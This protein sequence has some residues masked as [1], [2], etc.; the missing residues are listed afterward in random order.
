MCPKLKL[1]F[2]DG[3]E[4][5]GEEEKSQWIL[6]SLK[7]IDKYAGRCRIEMDVAPSTM[8]TLITMVADE[9]SKLEAARSENIFEAWQDQRTGEDLRKLR[10]SLD[11]AGRE[12]L[13]RYSSSGR[14]NPY[15]MRFG[16]PVVITFERD[17]ME[18]IMKEDL[19]S[20]KPPRGKHA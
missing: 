5:E 14:P 1:V 3:L 2:P 8:V 18:L 4:P 6:R 11:E 15:I 19:A 13:S 17:W 7:E 20:I 10:A 9:I 16:D 12:S